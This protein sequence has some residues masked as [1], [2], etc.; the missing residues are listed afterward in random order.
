MS[1]LWIFND[2]AV[3]NLGK[4]YVS[5]IMNMNIEL[6]SLEIVGRGRNGTN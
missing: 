4:L 5:L 6:I 2:E 3:I 1:K